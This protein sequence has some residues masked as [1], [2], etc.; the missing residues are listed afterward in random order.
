MNNRII[1][2]RIRYGQSYKGKS[3]I[4]TREYDF[5]ELLEY[6]KNHTNEEIIS[7]SQFTGLLD[8]NGKEIYEGDIVQTYF[9]DKPFSVG[10]VNFN[11]DKLQF[12][13]GYAPLVNINL[14]V[15]GNLFESPELIKQK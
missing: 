7:V 3:E 6:G 9:D 15:I 13:I 14:E 10:R 5:K 1:K 2:F 11:E 12:C 4:I 8:K